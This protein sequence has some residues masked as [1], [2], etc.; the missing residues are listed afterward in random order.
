[1]RCR[2][3]RL[4]LP[5]VGSPWLHGTEQRDSSHR[6]GLWDEGPCMKCCHP[7]CVLSRVL[8]SQLGS[9]FGS[10]FLPG[11]FPAPSTDSAAS[12]HSVCSQGGISCELGTCLP[13]PTSYS[14]R[15]DGFEQLSS[16]QW[17]PWLAEG[18]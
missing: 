15:A 11:G 12:S 16:L 5:A 13:G 4:L 6:G 3:W 18:H 9:S 17:L 8:L 1:M 10:D 7:S 14:P 2:V